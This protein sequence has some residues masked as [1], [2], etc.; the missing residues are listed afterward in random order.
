MP[1]RF[2]R[3]LVERITPSVLTSLRCG[4]TDSNDMV[5][6]HAKLTAERL[7]ESSP[8]IAAAVHDSSTAVVEV[9]Y[10]LA[11]GRA[12]VV[13]DPYRSNPPGH[14]AASTRRA[15]QVMAR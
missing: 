11:E 2:I 9:A 12:Q 6:D 1:P 4:R 8:V 10:P 3:D 7:L 14:V 13:T 15:P 5:F